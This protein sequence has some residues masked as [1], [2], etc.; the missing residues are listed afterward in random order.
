MN[1]KHLALAV[2]AA[3]ATPALASANEIYGRAHLSVDYLDNGD[4]GAVNVSSNS[5]RLGFRG[6][7][8]LDYGLTA[9]YQ[10]ESEVQF[11]REGS[12]IASRDSF[13][14]LRGDFG[15]LRLG[16]F[17]T[18]LKALRGRADFFGDQVGDARN[19]TR[20]RGL[21][22][23][24][25]GAQQGFDERFRNSIHYRTPSFGGVVL[26]VQY[27]TNEE[28]DGYTDN[29]DNDAISAA[30]SYSQGP[31]FAGIAY[32]TYNGD[33]D[34]DQLERDVIRAV[35]SYDFGVVRVAGLVQTASDPDDNVYGIGARW[36]VT[37]STGL[38]AQYYMLDADESD[39]DSQLFAIGVDHRLGRAATVYA[40]YA[41]VSNDDNA[42]VT[43][44]RE[45]RTASSQGVVGE[46]T[47][48]FSV[49]MIYNF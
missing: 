27:S 17:D 41:F 15:M 6:N 20:N 14:G 34:I 33:A 31:L 12:S 26:D 43:P 25:N 4:E 7:A 18:P 23:T 35:L 13:G 9:I 47:S 16:K 2:A 42:R 32:E 37:P 45:A 24:E 49:G 48:A 29:N 8:E 10:I 46:D 22:Q 30:I 28:A 36:A 21:T 19:I 39:Y 3:M 1:K 44:Y 11:D 5:S 38:R 40:N